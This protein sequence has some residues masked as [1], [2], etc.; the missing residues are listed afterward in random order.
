MAARL[1]RGLSGLGQPLALAALLPACSQEPLSRLRGTAFES[2]AELAFWG[3]DSDALAPLAQAVWSDL[4]T[5]D[6]TWHSTALLEA[7][8]R[9]A[10]ASAPAAL[11]TALSRTAA[12]SGAGRLLRDIL[13]RGLALDA[14]RP[15]IQYPDPGGAL[16]TLGQHLLALGERGFRPWHVGIPDPADGRTLLSFDLYADERLV[17]VARYARYRD[18]STAGGLAPPAGAGECASCSVIVRGALG[19]QAAA[20]AA[21]LY[22]C[23][24]ADWPEQARALSASNVLWVGHKG[25]I[26]G[27]VPVARRSLLSDQRRKITERT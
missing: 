18:G 5:L 20:T 24:A 6:R 16:I 9:A 13:L 14:I 3:I 8:L 4:A 23:S 2:P 27:T 12:E 1:S 17:T 11:V 7:Q 22:R 26:E 19:A 15:R 25:A 21:L 10:L